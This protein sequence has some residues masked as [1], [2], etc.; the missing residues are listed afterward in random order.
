MA[1]KDLYMPE[2]MVRDE[3][4]VMRVSGRFIRPMKGLK[5]CVDCG[6][7]LPED[8][9]VMCQCGTKYIKG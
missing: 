2:K 9:E 6:S 3:N 5:V 7:A 4:G 1:I 8:V